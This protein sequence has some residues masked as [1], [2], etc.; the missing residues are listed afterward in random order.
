MQLVYTHIASS[1][2]IL[3]IAIDEPSKL[4]SAIMNPRV[5]GWQY[6]VTYS[7]AHDSK[8]STE[9]S[10]GKMLEAGSNPAIKL[11]KWTIRLVPERSI[12]WLSLSLHFE[13]NSLQRMAVNKK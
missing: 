5:G 12:S 8:F 4:S 13:A 9:E 7:Q 10:F 6:L 11:L 1:N 3:V 2:H